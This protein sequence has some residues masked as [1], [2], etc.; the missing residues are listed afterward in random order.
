MD[1]FDPLRPTCQY[2]S[3]HVVRNLKA[4]RKHEL[5]CP[6]NPNRQNPRDQTSVGVSIA[7]PSSSDYT[8]QSMSNQFSSLMS[9]PYST[10]PIES[11]DSMSDDSVMSP[12]SDSGSDS[13]LSFDD[14]DPHYDEDELNRSGL[15]S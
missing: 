4:L 9:G 7:G 2:D 14:L 13:D 15:G 3:S 10:S 11:A 8:L 12:C 1:I 5:S 6:A